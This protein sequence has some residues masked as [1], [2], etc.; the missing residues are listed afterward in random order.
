MLEH[1][2]IV[3][4]EEPLLGIHIH[5]EARIS[6]VEIMKGDPLQPVEPAYHGSV[7]PGFFERRMCEE[8]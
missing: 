4:E 7:D 3:L 2:H 8:N 1:D 6:L 5:V